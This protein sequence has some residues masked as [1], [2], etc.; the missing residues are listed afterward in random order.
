MRRK[1]YI[2]NLTY[3]EQFPDSFYNLTTFEGTKL[4]PFFCLVQVI[5]FVQTMKTKIKSWSICSQLFSSKQS[6]IMAG[7]IQRWS[8]EVPRCTCMGGYIRGEHFDVSCR[9][10][11]RLPRTPLETLQRRS[12]AHLA[13]CSFQGGHSGHPLEWHI[14]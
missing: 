9:L 3:F 5:G 14:S 10:R 8:I 12:A 7:Y 11:L 13:A 4:A 6:F 2:Q 1:A